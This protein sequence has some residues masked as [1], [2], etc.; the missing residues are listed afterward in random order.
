MGILGDQLLGPAVLH[1]G[2]TDVVYH[3]F[4]VNDLPL[5]LG[6]VPLHQPQHIWF[7]HERATLHFLPIIRQHANLSSGAQSTSLHDPLTLILQIFGCGDT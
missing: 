5:I 7:M 6:H 3:R 2:V 4:M 1:N